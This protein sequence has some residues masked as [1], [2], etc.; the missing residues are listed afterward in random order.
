M[1]MS[2]S[3][4]NNFPF[5][6]LPLELQRQVLLHTGLIVPFRS[7]GNIQGVEIFSGQPL[8]TKNDSSD[9]CGKCTDLQRGPVCHCIHGL[10]PV[11]TTCT[12]YCFPLALFQTSR[13]VS[14]LAQEIT[15]SKNRIYLS[16][17]LSAN[18]AWLRSRP[19]DLLSQIRAL[20]MIITSRQ[21]WEW[22]HLSSSESNIQVPTEWKD[23]AAILDERPSLRNLTLSIDAAHTY[24]GMLEDEL[25]LGDAGIE[26]FESLKDVYKALVE[27][28]SSRPHFRSLNNFFVFWPLFG[29]LETDAERSVMGKDY[30]PGARG[31]IAFENRDWRLPHG[32]E[33]WKIDEDGEANQDW[34]DYSPEFMRN[35][36]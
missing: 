26:N 27:P 5:T 4:I 31:K 24:D 20:D 13:K 28:F 7:I 9:C 36:E 29:S 6:S 19:L 35:I 11:S 34:I 23:I 8:Y 25:I 21:L 1:A 14:Q 17:D 30:E 10:K 22:G 2:A 3:P 12:C 32:W 33:W 16:G 15:F 18:S